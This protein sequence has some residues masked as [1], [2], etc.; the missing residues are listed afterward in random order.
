MIKRVRNQFFIVSLLSMILI[1]SAIV[2]AINYINYRNWD[3]NT[4]YILDL[5]SENNGLIP[6]TMMMRKERGISPETPFISRFFTVYANVFKDIV[7]IDL[8]RVAAIEEEKAKNYAIELLGTG[9]SK[10]VIGQYKY[11]VNPNPQGY[12]MVFLDIHQMQENNRQLLEISAL[13]GISGLILISVL[14]WWLSGFIVKPAEETLRREKRFI[15]E[16]S[17]EI[18]TPLAIISASSDIIEMENGESEW[19]Q[20][21]RNQVM[22]LDSLTS[23][24][25]D[26]SKIQ[27]KNT[28]E[29]NTSVDL[30]D[31][32]E[33]VLAEFEAPME[34]RGLELKRNISENIKLRSS[35]S[36]VKQLITILLDN[37]VKY[38]I[39]NEIISVDLNQKRTPV[40]TVRNRS[41]TKDLEDITPWFE[42][43]YREDESRNSSQNGYGIG[44]SS[45]WEIAS[46]NG[47][48]IGGSVKEGIVTVTVVF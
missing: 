23:E 42:R 37:A 48:K 15:T 38:S 34:V 19:T 21:I 32:T 2:G 29:R 33:K 35:E 40:L 11:S 5:V 31:I 7:Y 28:R 25:I 30:S 44:L 46:L 1:T 10:G 24:L 3:K 4:D 14:L 36:D 45:A 8:S 27:E 39:L 6:G 26:L 43:F 17:H 41:N 18:K 20:S 16:A 22:K 12:T 47:W 13:V 9:V